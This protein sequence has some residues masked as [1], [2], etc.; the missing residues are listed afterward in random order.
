MNSGSTTQVQQ[1]AHWTAVIAT[2][3]VSVCMVIGMVAMS[4]VVWRDGSTELV[5]TAMNGIIN[6][7]G[8]FAVTMG[9]VV[10]GPQIVSAIL[11]RVRNYA[12]SGQ[13]AIPVSDP[14]PMAQ[15]TV[16]AQTTPSSTTPAA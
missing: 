1:T 5:Q 8:G 15:I 3:A 2:I 4:A 13:S 12:T 14:V 11:G 10:A 7:G 9:S 16:S 6:L